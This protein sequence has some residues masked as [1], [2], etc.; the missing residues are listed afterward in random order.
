MKTQMLP[1]NQFERVSLQ[2]Y[3]STHGPVQQ[4]ND[5]VTFAAYHSPLSAFADNSCAS[6]L[7]RGT[8]RHGI[9]APDCQQKASCGAGQAIPRSAPADCDW[10][11]AAAARP[12]GD[13]GPRACPLPD[14]RRHQRSRRCAQLGWAQPLVTPRLASA[15]WR[16]LP[17]RLPRARALRHLQ[18]CAA[19]RDAS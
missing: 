9:S 4:C 11:A 10:L 14:Y 13:H 1:S 6:T 18:A 17:G 8:H 15:G 19:S 16:M 7:N 5:A 3:H 12:R 2:D